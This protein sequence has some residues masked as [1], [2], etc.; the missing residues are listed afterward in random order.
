MSRPALH[1]AARYGVAVVSVAVALA[2]NLSV[3]L[4][5]LPSLADDQDASQVE[6]RSLAGLGGRLVT[7]MALKRPQGP[8]DPS[9]SQ[10]TPQGTRTATRT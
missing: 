9:S 8:A 1:F 4:E 10:S 2:L 7:P 3:S 5:H 6:G